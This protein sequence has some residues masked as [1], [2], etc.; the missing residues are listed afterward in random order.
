MGDFFRSAALKA[1][2]SGVAPGGFADAA[3]EVFSARRERDNP[4]NL[5][6]RLQIAAAD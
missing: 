3:T 6:S 1:N 5:S 4:T 2:P